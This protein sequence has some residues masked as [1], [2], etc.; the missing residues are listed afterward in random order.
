MAEV[1]SIMSSLLSLPVSLPVCVCLCVTVGE[2]PLV[3]SAQKE[4]IHRLV[5]SRLFL[6]LS[7]LADMYNVLRILPMVVV[8]V[9]SVMCHTVIMSH[10]HHVTQSSRHTVVTSHSH[11]TVT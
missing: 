1:H 5:Q 8:E 6:P 3:H 4:A 2:P 7:P 11:T 9:V 10:S